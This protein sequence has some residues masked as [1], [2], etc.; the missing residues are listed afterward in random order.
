MLP[1]WLSIGALSFVQGVLVGL[2]RP[3]VAIPL[4]SRVGGRWWALVLPLSIVV[5]IG[6]IALDE[7]SAHFLTWLALIAVPPLAAVALGWIVHGARP[8]LALLAVPL[9]ALAWAAKGELGGQSAALALSALACV[10]LGWLLVC[11]VPA[12]WVKLG[13]YAMAIVD[14]YLV[15]TDLLQAPNSVLNTAAPAADLP[16]LQLVSWGSAIMGFGDLFIAAVLG[17]L[18]ARDRRLQLRGALLAAGL[19]CAWDLLFFFIHETPATVPVA[20]TLLTLELWGRWSKRPL[21]SAWRRA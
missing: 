6:A 14:A 10:T 11:V 13:I 18:L 19:C 17:A 5:V 21:R 12:R 16:K 15:F 9:F 8:P 3:T 20:L 7:S 1:F 2:P 4:L